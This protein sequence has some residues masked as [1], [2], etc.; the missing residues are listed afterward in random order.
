[1]FRKKVLPLVLV[2]LLLGHLALPFAD[3]ST[4]AGRSGPNFQVNKVTFD[5]DNGSI[6]DDTRFVL[7]P[8]GHLSLIHI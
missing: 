7:A 3:A 1:M 2:V 5:G 4:T 6:N 8:G